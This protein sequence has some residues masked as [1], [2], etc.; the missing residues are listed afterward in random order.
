MAFININTN[1]ILLNKIVPFCRFIYTGKIFYDSCKLVGWISLLD[2]ASKLE[3]FDL[4]IAIET[5]LIEKQKEWIQ[6][7]II[8]VHE[9]AL[10]AA[11]LNRLLGYCNRLM[12]SHP[13]IIFKSNNFATL[14]K[15]TL[16]NLLKNDDLSMEEDDIWMLVMQWATKQVPELELGNDLNIDNW[17]SNDIN[18][19]KDIIADCIPHIRFFNMSPDKALLFDDLLP[20]KLRRDILNCQMKNDYVPSTTILLPRTGQRCN[21]DSV[22]N[23]N[24]QVQY[25]PGDFYEDG[26]RVEKDIQKA[27]ELYKR[28]VE[29]GNAT[30]QYNLGYCY[31]HGIGVEK[32]AGK[33]VELYH[34]AAEQGNAA[35]QYNIGWC[36]TNGTRVEKNARKAVE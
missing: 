24:K 2:G 35:A 13:D 25:N 9:Y 29:Q 32:D 7:N 17:S 16:I 1:A 23:N 33:S 26:I 8:T 30:A 28:A 34:Q 14:P 15:E 27:V 11:P 36:Y 20:R 22:I 4:L 21:I 18:T 10:S 3:L 31:R 19:V 5:Y 12:V 6:Q